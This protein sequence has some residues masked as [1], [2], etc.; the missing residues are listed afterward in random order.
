MEKVTFKNSRDLR[1][2][3]DFYKADSNLGIVMCHGFTGDRHELGKLDKLAYA[4]NNKGFNVLNFDFSG[5][6]ES[7]DDSLTVSKQID[8][9]KCAVKYIK[10]QGIKKIGLYG[11]SLGGLVCFK[12][13]NKSIETIAASAPVTKKKEDYAKK[14][15]SKEQLEE[16]ENTGLITRVREKDKY[17]RTKIVIDKQMIIDRESVNQKELLSRV[18]CPVLIVHGAKDIGVPTQDSRSAMQYLSPESKLEILTQDGHDFAKSWPKAIDF[19]SNWFKK[20]LS[21][22]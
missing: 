19:V 7:D 18:K 14:R 12:Y 9:L 16:L 21:S 17:L 8:D 20:Y 5:S 2:V 1:L 6:G 22:S 13:Y 11:H 3:G 4:L 10:G 15:F